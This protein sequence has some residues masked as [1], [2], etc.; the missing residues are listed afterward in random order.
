[1]SVSDAQ[2]H[3]RLGSEDSLAYQLKNGLA[4]LKTW[5]LVLQANLW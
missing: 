2:S 4:P 5:R 1:M 3:W